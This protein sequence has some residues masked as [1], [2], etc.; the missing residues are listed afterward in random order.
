MTDKDLDEFQKDHWHV[1]GT[2]DYRVADHVCADMD[3]L[4]LVS[5]CRDRGAEIAR[6][7]ALARKYSDGWREDDL[8]VRLDRSGN[9]MSDEECAVEV[10]HQARLREIDG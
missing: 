7:K 8:L 4:L 5:E 2:T 10:E 1:S 3:C 9:D 6:L